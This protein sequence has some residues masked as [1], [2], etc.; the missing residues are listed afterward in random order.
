MSDRIESFNQYRV[1]NNIDE[2]QPKRAK[3]VITSMTADKLLRNGLKP[4][5][6]SEE[7]IL[8]AFD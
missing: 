5:N 6:K 3:N 8:Y 1:A 2:W 7:D 4:L